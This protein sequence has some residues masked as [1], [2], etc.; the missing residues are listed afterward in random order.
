MK[1]MYILAHFCL[2]LRSASHAMKTIL[3]LSITI[4]LLLLAFPYKNAYADYK[5]ASQS[6]EQ[7]DKSRENTIRL[8]KFLE[9]QD[10]ELSIYADKF[11]EIANK[12]NLRYSLLPAICGRESTFAKHYIRGTYNCYGWGP[13]IK[14]KSWEDGIEKVAKGIK[15]NYVQK[16]GKSTVNEI[17]TIYAESKTWASG[18]N[19]F[20]SMI[21][22]TEI[23]E[24][25]SLEPSL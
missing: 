17:G 14:F 7:E 2:G 20:I 1:V 6:E 16:W 19:N 10:S 15:E 23:P 25:H 21:E 22:S 8:K 18:V 13:S 24:A 12:Y 11:V 9:K 4:I 3:S 5:V